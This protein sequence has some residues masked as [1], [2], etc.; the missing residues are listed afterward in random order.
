MG[1][2]AVGPDTNHLS[3]KLLNA[4]VSDSRAGGPFISARGLLFAVIKCNGDVTH[5][6]L[7]FIAA[8][9]AESGG[10]SVC[11][12]LLELLNAP[13]SALSSRRIWKIWTYISFAREMA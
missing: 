7:L 8:R 3:G 12:A 4:L 10:Q 6:D 11:F 5:S 2:A 1:S 13:M 9:P